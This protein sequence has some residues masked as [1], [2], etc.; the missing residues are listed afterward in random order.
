MEETTTSS[1]N[2]KLPT[3]DNMP[4]LQPDKNDCSSSDSDESPIKDRHHSKHT[5]KHHHHHHQKHSHHS[6]HHKHHSKSRSRS[7]SHSHSGEKHKAHK[8]E[9][10]RTSSLAKSLNDVPIVNQSLPNRDS[11]CH[12]SE[13]G[14]NLKKKDSI[15]DKDTSKFFFSMGAEEAKPAIQF[16][17]GKPCGEN[18]AQAQASKILVSQSNNTNNNK[19]GTENVECKEENKVLAIN[20]GMSLI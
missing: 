1:N 11:A 3:N 18:I 16:L 6:H 7:R 13:E 15:D 8:S 17:I 4:K 12:S 14:Y 20:P 19:A 2:T 10:S 5:K 9:I